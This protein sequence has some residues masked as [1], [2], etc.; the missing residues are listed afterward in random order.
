M[1]KWRLVEALRD[2]DR[3]LETTFTEEEFL[4]RDSEAI[5]CILMPFFTVDAKG[6]LGAWGHPVFKVQT[7]G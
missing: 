2:A 5:V 3:M 7:A 1:E 6:R 4:L